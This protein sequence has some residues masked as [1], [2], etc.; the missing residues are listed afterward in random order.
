MG[1]KQG[2]EMKLY[3]CAE[4][5]G[6]TPTWTELAIVQDVKLSTSKG[7]ADVT[8][9]AAGGWKQTVGTLV[10]ASI[11]FEMPWDTEDD[12]FQ[13]VKDAYFGGTLIGLCLADDALGEGGTFPAGTEVF[14]A[15]C[16]ILKFDRS[17]PLDGAVTVAVTAKP[18]YSANPPVYEVIEE[19]P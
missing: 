8:T 11:E 14:R 3:W 13:A 6:G 5:I 15:D 4:G 2:G 1:V 19:S 9:R 12:G 16:A 10:D 17:E 18:T 7:E